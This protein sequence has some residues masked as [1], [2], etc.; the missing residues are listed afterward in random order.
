VSGFRLY[1]GLVALS[2][3][4]RI[5]QGTLAADDP[6]LFLDPNLPERGLE[7]GA[8]QGEWVEDWGPRPDETDVQA[9]PQAAAEGAAEAKKKPQPAK[10]T[11]DDF[12]PFSQY[13][14]LTLAA[15][16]TTVE[17]AD[18]AV[19]LRRNSIEEVLMNSGA[20]TS[21]SWSG[22]EP[23]NTCGSIASG[24]PR[25]TNPSQSPPRR[26]SMPQ[27]CASCR[28]K[29]GPASVSTIGMICSPWPASPRNSASG[30]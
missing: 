15:G 19:K 25:T 20:L 28:E 11:L 26:A 29:S 7:A 17:Q 27:C 9:E 14:I 4:S 3:T 8:D 30:P 23:P 12:D 13:M 2:A 18:Q 24:W 6:D 22:A 5:T 21:M 16:I 1:P 10:N